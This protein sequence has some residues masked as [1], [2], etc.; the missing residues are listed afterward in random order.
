MRLLYVADNG[1]SHQDGKF[2]MGKVNRVNSEQY[3][4]YFDNIIYIGRDGCYKDD[5]EPV[6]SNVMIRLVSRYGYNEV[7]RAMIEMQD[8]YDVVLVRNGVLGCFAAKFASHLGKP[9]ISY[10]GSDP[11]DL[12]MAKHTFKEM[13]IAHVWRYFERRKMQYADFAYYCTKSLFLKYPCKC[14]YMICSNVEIDIDNNALIDRLQ[15]QSKEHN[16]IILGLIG[17]YRENDIKGISTVISALSILGK[18]YRFEIVGNGNPNQF[19]ELMDKL[20]VKEQV[21][22]NGFCSNRKELNTW[23]DSV[24]IYLQPSISEGLPRATIE[25]MARA[26]PV[27]ASNVGGMKDLLSED[28]LIE[29]KDFKTLAKKILAFNDINSINMASKANFAKASEFAREVRDSKMDVFFNNIL[30]AVK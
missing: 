15:R 24:D 23:L 21:F 30:N 6:S 28:Y 4:K 2:F 10:C 16:P 27:I 1:F 3:R 5:H 22:F 7:K 29:P 18:N 25:A 17:Q 19:S 20:K 14:D 26:C 8:Q 12:F 13:V 11:F 9:L